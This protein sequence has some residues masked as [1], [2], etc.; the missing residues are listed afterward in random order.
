MNAFIS[1]VLWFFSI[2]VSAYLSGSILWAIIVSKISGQDVRKLGTQNPGM[3]NTTR[4]LGAKYGSVVLIG[5]VLTAFFTL[6]VIK[7]LLQNVFD[8]HPSAFIVFTTVFLLGAF[9]PIFHS[10]K[11][12]S[13]LAKLL[14]ILLTLNPLA[15][16]IN[17]PLAI[18][19]LFTI[20]NTEWKF[21]GAA[22][23]I[24]IST[25]ILSSSFEY[26]YDAI[27]LQYIFPDFWGGVCIIFSGLLVLIRSEYQYG[28]FFLKFLKRFKL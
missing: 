14:G 11:G 23:Y 19:F 27:R 9:F 1:N 15:F 22:V 20:K 12:G 26:S 4:E 21:V 24:V 25:I 10:F 16:L 13:G 6:F 3:A 28:L 2:S 17:A 5:D 7:Y 18:L 8:L